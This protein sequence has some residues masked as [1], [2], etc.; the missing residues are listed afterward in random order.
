MRTS[1]QTCANL[2]PPTLNPQTLI[3]FDWSGHIARPGTSSTMFAVKRRV[4]QQFDHADI[5]TWQTG[6]AWFSIDIVCSYDNE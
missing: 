6:S 2:N 3:P 5:V 1:V 4:N